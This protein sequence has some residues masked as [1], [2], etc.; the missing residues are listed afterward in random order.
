MR[1]KYKA[2]LVLALLTM[3]A[4][5]PT[6]AAGTYTDPF[7]FCKAAGN[8][9]SSGEGGISDRRYVGSQTP[10]QVVA[11]IRQIIPN[12]P[13]TSAV[14]RC[15]SGGVY[16]CYLGASGRAC[17]KMG[18]STPTASLKSYCQA[19]PNTEVPN[20]AND[21]SAQWTCDNRTPVLDKR[22]PQAELDARGYFKGSWRK[23]EP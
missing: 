20:S 18:G 23:V 10:P 5:T 16:A 12:A 4:A 6:E 8:V 1:S 11:I 13:E 2:I 19:N 15:M 22:Y 7:A 21:T 17:M 3:L 14:W 9:D